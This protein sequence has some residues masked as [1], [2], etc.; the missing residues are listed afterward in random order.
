MLQK[1]I[2]NLFSCVELSPEFLAEL[3]V[4]AVLL[5][6]IKWTFEF[7]RGVSR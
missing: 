3:L 1:L 6:F 4:L 7:A 5:D 2:E